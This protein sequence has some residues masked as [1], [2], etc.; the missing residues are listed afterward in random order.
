M[1]PLVKLV[2]LTVIIYTHRQPVI[3]RNLS[4]TRIK[5]MM[6]FC[7]RDAGILDVSSKMLNMYIILKLESK[8]SIF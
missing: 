7:K 1:S 3:H 4:I 5:F 6:L 2:N 8:F